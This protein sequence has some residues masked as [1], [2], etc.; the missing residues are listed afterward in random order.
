MTFKMSQGDKYIGIHDGMTD[1]RFFDVCLVDRDNRFVRALESIGNQY[2]T[3]GLQRGE[4]VDISGIQMV[5]CIFTAADI[6]R[7]AVGEER[8][9]TAFF[10]VVSHDFRVVWTQE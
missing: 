9:A 6:E 1:L 3:S 10:D 8:L 2:M 5:E 7:V 4:A